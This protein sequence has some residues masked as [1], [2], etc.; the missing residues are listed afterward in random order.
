MQQEKNNFQK[1][2]DASIMSFKTSFGAPRVQ[3][4]HFLHEER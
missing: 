1:I 2:N 4:L 3:A